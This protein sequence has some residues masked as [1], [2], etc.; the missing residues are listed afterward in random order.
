[1]RT[2]IAFVIPTMDLG[3]AE[4][5]LCLLAENL[6]RKEYDVRVYLLTRDGPRSEQLR[7]A[8]IPVI[9]I[10]KRFKLDPT[11]LIRLKN[12]LRSF[13]PDIV[14]TWLFAANSFGRLAASLAAVPRIYAS[15]RCV[16]PWKTSFHLMI[17]RWFAKKTLKITTNSTGVKAFYVSKGLDSD[18]FEVI[19]NGIEQAV[20]GSIS[21]EEAFGRLKVQEDR[22]LILAVGRLWPQKRYRDLIWATELL[23]TLRED[24]TL[25]ILGDGPLQAELMRFRDSVTS[26][27]RVRFAGNRGD[28]ASLLPHAN[29]FWIGSEYEGQS[30]S[31]IEAMQAGL[32]VVASDIPGNT[33]LV[34]DRI[35]GR[36]YPLGDRAALA[37]CSQWLFENPADAE[38]LGRAA[39]ERIQSD[40][41]VKAMVERYSELYQR[42]MTE[43]ERLMKDH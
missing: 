35:T 43:R 17:D 2:K 36:L 22:K 9:L 16:D 4:K 11:A 30:N 3:G 34:T 14:H 39:R 7:S 32:P 23:A 18:L 29:Q 10:G 31:L 12:E 15:E 37:R 41:T 28:V 33:D 20:P 24:I 21:R 6:P 25:V 19:P 26:V 27:D 1:M 40:F 8:G 42:S 5:Q 38:Q 13:Q